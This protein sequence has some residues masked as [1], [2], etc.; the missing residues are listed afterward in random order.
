MRDERGG[1]AA[2]AERWR[3]R[4]PLARSIGVPAKGVQGRRPL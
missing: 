4:A 2:V 3:W 1:N